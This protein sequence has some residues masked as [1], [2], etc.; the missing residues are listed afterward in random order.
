MGNAYRQGMLGEEIK[1]IISRMLLRQ[2]KDPRLDHMISVVD[3]EVTKDGSYATCWI[4]VLDLA[5]DEAKKKEREEE[6]ISGLESAKGKIRQEIGREIKLRR[7]PDLIFKI[8][9]S[10]DYGRHIDQVLRDIGME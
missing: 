9:H 6:V 5:G 2:L 8:D 4:T 10:E 7:V 3:V 1:K